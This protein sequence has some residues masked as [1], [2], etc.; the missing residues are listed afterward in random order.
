[1][2]CR[3]CFAGE[4]TMPV[5]VNATAA[6]VD[7]LQWCVAG[8]SIQRLDE[9]LQATKKGSPVL[10]EI[11]LGTLRGS[12]GN[13]NPIKISGEV[14]VG[15]GIVLVKD[16]GIFHQL[17][18]FPKAFASGC[19]GPQRMTLLLPGLGNRL[20]HIPATQ[21]GAPFSRGQDGFL[22]S[23]QQLIEGGQIRG[24]SHRELLDTCT[25]VNDRGSGR[26]F[27]AYHYLVASSGL[28]RFP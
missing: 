4:S 13:Q 6:Q 24:G 12:E 16:Q 28:N 18:E 10:V 23:G 14:D 20:A 27:C 7:K 11:N 1:M 22:V 21:D 17:G 5:A 25:F 9:S 8:A 2:V 26:R 3:G 19:G 15:A